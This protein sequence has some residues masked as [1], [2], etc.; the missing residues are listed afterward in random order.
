MPVTATTARSASRRMR[1]AASWTRWYVRRLRG[2]MAILAL[3][4]PSDPQFILR[5]HSIR[6]GG[7]HMPVYVVAQ[8]TI[9][10]KGRY[11]AHSRAFHGTLEPFGGSL[12]AA[13]EAPDKVSGSWPYDKFVLIRFAT[14]EDAF[15]WADS[16]EYRRISVDLEA[17]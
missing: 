5:T 14:S 10:D 6:S 7:L 3:E 16:P 12:L 1:C 17:A 9:H 13:Y 15:A 2:V 4:T 11:G 8:L